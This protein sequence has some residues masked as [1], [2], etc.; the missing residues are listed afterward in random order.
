MV[1]AGLFFLV[2]S[3]VIVQRLYF[4]ATKGKRIWKA[5]PLHHHFEMK[6][7]SEVTIVLRFWLISACFG[8]A[9]IAIVYF[10]WVRR[11]GI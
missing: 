2:T 3:Q 11:V 4:K 7:W 5:S 8:V 6:G 9:G 10:E 1:I